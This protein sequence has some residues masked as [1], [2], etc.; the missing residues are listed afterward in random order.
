LR[1]PQSFRKRLRKGGRSV[2]PIGISRDPLSARARGCYI[3]QCWRFRAER[4]AA[5]LNTLNQSEELAAVAM[6]RLRQSHG[7][8]R[9]RHPCIAMARTSPVYV[10]TTPASRRV[11]PGRGYRVSVACCRARGFAAKAGAGRVRR[12]APL[13]LR[14]AYRLSYTTKTPV[15]TNACAS[16]GNRSTSLGAQIAVRLRADDAASKAKR[17]E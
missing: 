8:Q 6:G 1:T 9:Y 17:I 5:R 4:D 3:F 12:R 11:P 13:R 15:K 16:R 10:S 14:H 2:D 7:E